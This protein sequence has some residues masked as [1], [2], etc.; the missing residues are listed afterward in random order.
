MANPCV[1]R[2]ILSLADKF[3]KADAGSLD[4]SVEADKKKPHPHDVHKLLELRSNPVLRLYDQTLD[5]DG[6]SRD[7]QRGMKKEIRRLFP[8]ERL[9]VYTYLR[10]SAMLYKMVGDYKEWNRYLEAADYLRRTFKLK[11]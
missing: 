9:A 4:E 6:L 7:L 10:D 5:N 1:K 3:L 8:E 11:V 2:D